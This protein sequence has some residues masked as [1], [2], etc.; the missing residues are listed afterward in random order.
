MSRYLSS[1]TN[2][3]DLVEAWGKVKENAPLNV[4][5]FE[6]RCKYCGSREISKYGRYNNVQRWWCKRCKRK[7]TDNHAPPGMK[8]PLDMIH[9][10]ISLY[11]KG[12]PIITIRKQLLEDYN[13]YPSESII[14]KWIYRDTEKTLVYTR[15]HKPRVGDSWIVF[16]SSIIIGADKFWI[17][18]IVD[19]KT[20]F[21]LASRFSLNR[22]IEDF[23]SLIKLAEEKA[24]KIPCEILTRRKFYKEIALVSGTGVRPI[25]IKHDQIGMHF[26][27]YWNFVIRVRRKILC[28]QKLL[29][30]AQLTLNGWIFYQ[31]YIV[32]QKS[33]N[34]KTAS[35][36]AAIKYQNE[37]GLLVEK[38][39][40]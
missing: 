16:E 17:L 18:D 11:Y 12:V 1:V 33:L 38:Y 14:H 23:R 26:T 29:N 5:F 6:I 21:L 8:T 35:Q 19:L 10:A 3:H 20:H 31:N 4:V 39:R 32:T 22:D 13:Y 27:T 36:E 40:L 15:D 7:F 25:D 2:Y 9:S 28:R 24:K 37:T 30:L 34:E